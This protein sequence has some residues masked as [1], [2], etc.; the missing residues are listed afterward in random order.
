M[1]E[2][3]LR[4]EIGYRAPMARARAGS[5]TSSGT[6]SAAP[7][8]ELVRLDADRQRA[9]P[10]VQHPRGQQRRRPAGEG[11]GELIVSRS[12]GVL[13]RDVAVALRTSERIVRRARLAAGVDAERGRRVELNG[14]GKGS[15]LGLEL[16]RAGLSV[17]AASMFAGVPR[18]TLWGSLAA[19]GLSELSASFGSELEGKAP[20][21]ARCAI[22]CPRAPRELG[23]GSCGQRKTE[24]PRLS[25]AFLRALC[26]TRTGTPF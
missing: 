6:G 26:R 14:N 22:H 21:E 10:L 13:A 12:A 17:R 11:L 3:E 23:T 7:P 4:L 2:A 8:V 19:R 16:L 18:S 24:K 20:R 25:G 15:E 9:V 1:G 5:R